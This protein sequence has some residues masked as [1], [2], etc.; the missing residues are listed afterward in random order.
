MSNGT[1]TRVK[2]YS[3][4]YID[5]FNRTRFSHMTSKNR[6]IQVLQYVARHDGCKRIDIIRD[7]LGYGDVEA[8]DP[9]YENMR[10]CRGH[11]SS[12]FSQLLYLNVIDYDKKF[13]YHITN[14]G[15]E[16]LKTAFQ[17]DVMRCN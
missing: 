4:Q 3:T 7:V 6:C 14:Q 13:C 8:K 1:W 10:A 11:W 5:S 15:L 2:P 9:W 17:N 12:G 16:V